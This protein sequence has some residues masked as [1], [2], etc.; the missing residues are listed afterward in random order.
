MQH[1]I[2]DNKNVG[3]LQI[4]EGRLIMLYDCKIMELYR[5]SYVILTACSRN[6][7]NQTIS[8]VYTKESSNHLNND[9]KELSSLLDSLWVQQVYK[10]YFKSNDDGS[11]NFLMIMIQQFYCVMMHLIHL[12]MLLNMMICRLVHYWKPHIEEYII[13]IDNHIWLW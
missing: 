7:K 13:Q 8:W 5:F 12:L 2:G 10:E 6:M 1:K 9:T 4:V 3:L 11:L